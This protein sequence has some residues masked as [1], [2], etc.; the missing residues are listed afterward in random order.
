MLSDP[1]FFAAIFVTATGYWLVPAALRLW[2]LTALSLVVIGYYDLFSLALLVVLSAGVYPVLGLVARGGRRGGIA[3]AVSIASVSGTLIASKIW[4]GYVAPHYADSAL[5]FVSI[6]GLSYYSFRL[7]HLIIDAYRF[8]R[9][10]ETPLKFAAFISLFTVFVSGPIQRYDEAFAAGFDARFDLDFLKQGLTRIAVGVVKQGLVAAWLVAVRDNVFNNR[11]DPITYEGLLDLAIGDVWAI[12]LLTY[13]IT[14][15]SLG[16][17]TDVAIGASRLMGLKV[18][19]NFRA[20]LIATSPADFWRRW[21]LS[22]SSWCQNYV[23]APVLGLT[24]HPFLAI[25]VSFQVMG[26]WHML[27]LNRIIW[28]ALHAGGVI[29]SGS[30]ERRIRRRGGRRL[31]PR[32]ITA[33]LGWLLTQLF[34]GSTFLFVVLERRNDLGESLAAYWHL[35]TLGLW[36]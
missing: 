29:V 30:L 4:S 28:G 5:S 21:H 31:I 3:L 13:W 2:F 11:V 6:L 19:E 9:Y 26:L 24:R 23:Y 7:I 35:W 17:Y 8:G 32:L 14:Y 27:T 34:I 33:P 12:C 10:P 16:A 20:P 15:F 25:A 22:L 36:G 18:M 1:L